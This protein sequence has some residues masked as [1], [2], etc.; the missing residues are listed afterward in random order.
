MEGFS[1]SNVVTAHSETFWRA[2]AVTFLSVGCV[3]PSSGRIGGSVNLDG[4]VCEDL[5]RDG[6]WIVG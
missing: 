3:G 1:H 6:G 2:S 5:V 4:G